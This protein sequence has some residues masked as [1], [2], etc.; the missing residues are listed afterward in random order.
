MNDFRDVLIETGFLD[1]RIHILH[2][3]SDVNLETLYEHCLFTTFPS[4]V[5]GWGLPVGE[6]LTHDRAYVASKSSLI[7]E[8]GGDLSTMSTR[9]ASVTVSACFG[10]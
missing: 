2:D 6:S 3:L 8:A 4:I 1:G 7:P 10:E 9:L 5:E